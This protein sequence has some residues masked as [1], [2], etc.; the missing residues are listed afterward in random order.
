MTQTPRCS[1]SPPKLMQGCDHITDR[2]VSGICTSSYVLRCFQLA[3]EE[4]FGAVEELR[5][6]EDGTSGRLVT[7]ARLG[8]SERLEPWNHRGSSTIA[9]YSHDA[10]FP[11]FK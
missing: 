5:L 3:G 6:E 7:S 10:C 8:S 9:A 4:C 2:S 11:A 1:Q